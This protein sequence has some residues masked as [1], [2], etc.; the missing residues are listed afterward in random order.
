MHYSAQI[1]ALASCSLLSGINASPLLSR[2][3]DCK[4]GA[5]SSLCWEQM[6]L[7]SYMTNDFGHAGLCKLGQSWSRCFLEYAFDDAKTKGEMDCSNLQSTKCTE[8]SFNKNAKPFYG[9]YNIWS[10][11]SYISS[12]ANAI[13][14]ITVEDPDVLKL[15]AQTEAEDLPTDWANAIKDFPVEDPNVQ[16]EAEDLKTD[17]VRN[18]DV[19][20]TNLISHF[21][22]SDKGANEAF[23]A[24]MKANPSVHIYDSTKSSGVNIGNQLQQRLAELLETIST[25]LPSFVSLVKG[26][27][28]S[29]HT[30]YGEESIECALVPKFCSKASIID[31]TATIE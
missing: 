15:N 23:I 17:Y 31:G 5:K 9:A 7:T 29:R 18:I 19:A 30:L 3:I 8:P 28:F 27:E 25:D 24:F 22:I 20:L 11:W 4:S 2:E 16:T 1:V 13:E 10:T 6:D 21:D 26:G 14:A 12:W